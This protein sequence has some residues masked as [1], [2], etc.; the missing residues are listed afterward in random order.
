MGVGLHPAR[1]ERA[2][3]R[4]RKRSGLEA[5]AIALRASGIRLIYAGRPSPPESG[6]RR[7]VATETARRG[8]SIASLDRPDAGSRATSTSA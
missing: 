7:P 8:D 3:A 1:C 4:L 5:G 2:A 6:G